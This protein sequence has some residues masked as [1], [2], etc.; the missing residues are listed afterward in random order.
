MIKKVDDFA[1]TGKIIHCALIILFVLARGIL[2][3]GVILL[4]I[5]HTFKLLNKVPIA[6][7]NWTV[8]IRITSLRKNSLMLMF[9]L[10]KLGPNFM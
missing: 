3:Y 5:T 8:L 2:I 10:N 1:N 4:K 7:F 9:Y 6:Y